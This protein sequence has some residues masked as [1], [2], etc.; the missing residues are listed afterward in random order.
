MLG[1]DLLVVFSGKH[2]TEMPDRRVVHDG[3]LVPPVTFSA[4]GVSPRV[5]RISSWWFNN[6]ADYFGVSAALG[7]HSLESL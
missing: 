4:G 5:W 3:D 2:I 1:I 7:S 6:I